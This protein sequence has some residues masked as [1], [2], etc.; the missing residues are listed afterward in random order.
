M[1][2]TATVADVKDAVTKKHSQNT[3][4]KLDEGGANEITA[5]QIKTD[6]TKLS[7]IEESAVA[8]TTVKAD[9][10]ISDAI[11]KKHAQN[12]DSQ[13]IDG[14]TSLLVDDTEGSE[15]LSFKVNTVEKFSVDKNG[16]VSLR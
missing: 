2:N 13:I 14:D 9:S 12:S 6:S 15:K 3:D 10:D 8:L 4:T 1:S 5:A 16:A 11:S 7:G